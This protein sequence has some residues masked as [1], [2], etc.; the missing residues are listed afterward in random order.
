MTALPQLA[1]VLGALPLLLAAAAGF[2]DVLWHG[3]G[4]RPFEQALQKGVQPRVLLAAA[5]RREA[6]AMCNAVAVILSVKQC[7]N[8]RQRGGLQQRCTSRYSNS[9]LITNGWHSWA[10]IITMW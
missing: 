5:E 2:A 3:D 9:S 4:L 7:V 6:H 10:I 8:A 1:R